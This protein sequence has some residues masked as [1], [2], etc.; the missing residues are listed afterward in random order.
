MA[1]TI[2]NV[3][4]VLKDGNVEAAKGSAK[5]R[6]GKSLNKKLIELVKPKLPITV[7][8]YAEHPLGELLIANAF[9]GAIIKFG[10]TND[11][12]VIASECMVEA[13]ADKAMDILNIDGILDEL[14]GSVNFDI[15]TEAKKDDTGS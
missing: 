4:S 10:Y 11:K 15:L 1:L 3:V 5:R 13:A 6:V 12:V 14:L 9:A 8:G 2:N 7:R